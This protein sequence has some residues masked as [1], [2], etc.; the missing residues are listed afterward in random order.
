MSS[1]SLTFTDYGAI[2]SDA[3][4]FVTHRLTRPGPFFPGQWSLHRVVSAYGSEFIGHFPSLDAGVDYVKS[5]EH[6]G[7][8]T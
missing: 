1:L 8:D 5:N 2:L 3:D 6:P 4:G 7:V